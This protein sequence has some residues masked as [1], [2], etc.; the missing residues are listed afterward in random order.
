MNARVGKN[1]AVLLI[2]QVSV[3]ALALIFN[4]QLGRILG[5]GALGRYLGML[6]LEGLCLALISL[7]L[8]VYLTRELSR[9]EDRKMMEQLLGTAL[10]IRIVSG[11]IGIAL[12]NLVV[13]RIFYDASYHQLSL[14]VSVALLPDAV[15]GVLTAF[16]R[17][18]QRME[19]SS[20]IELTAR[21]LAVALGLVT[22]WSGLDELWALAA[23]VVSRIVAV[24]LLFIFLRQWHI[25]PSWLSIHKWKRMLRESSP[26]AIT[27]IVAILY[28]KFDILILP[29]WHGDVV[30]G[31]YG[32]A[33][34][35]WENLGLIPSSFLEALFPEMVRRTQKN[36][37]TD[38]QVL[39]AQ[40]SRILAVV[41][42]A[43]CVIFAVSAPIVFQILYGDMVGR[44]QSMRIFRWLLLG[45]PFTYFYLLDGNMLYALN[46]QRVV[47]HW[48]IIVTLVNIILNLLLIPIGESWAAMGVAVFSS[49]V[50]YVGLHIGV[51]QVK[52]SISA[53]GIT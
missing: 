13:S 8:N 11:I 30:V 21:L 47:T 49:I 50:L 29:R 38:I 28:R 26:F 39:Y 6:A 16:F 20:G 27:D 43:M 7:G 45:L 48:M 36:Q 19:I 42:L 23:F 40:T 25:R 3:R 52:R 1:A 4:A 37:S 2:S 51:T 18:Q 46:Q 22:L 5:I 10:S 17:S 53:N 12:L 14:I 35:L 34:S 41:V 33:Y 15:H 9:T 31:I 24:I 44:N 32:A